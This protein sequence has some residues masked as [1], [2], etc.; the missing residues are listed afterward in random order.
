[1]DIPLFQA[2]LTHA[3]DGYTV[4]WITDHT[5]DAAQFDDLMAALEFLRAKIWAC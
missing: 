3:A 5:T 1:M 4:S 2:C